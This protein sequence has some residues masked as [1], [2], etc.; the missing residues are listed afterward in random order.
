MTFVPK[1]P[2]DWDEVECPQCDDEPTWETK[3]GVIYQIWQMTSSHL[4][5]T[6][7]YLKRNSPYGGYIPNGEQ[8]AYAFDQMCDEYNEILTC[9]ETEW[10][11]RRGY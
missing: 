5:N 2:H 6:I 3:E 4:I 11:R 1:H 8:A 10:R 9:M 7:N